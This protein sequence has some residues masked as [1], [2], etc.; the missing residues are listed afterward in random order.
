MT[1]FLITGA[2]T[3]IGR[4]TAEALGTTGNT[5]WLACRSEDKA[6]P[7]A[8]AIARRG[9]HARIVALDLGDLASVRRAASTVLTDTEPLHVLI[10]NAGI[11]GPRG[12]TKDGFEITFGTNHL[13]PFLLTRLLLPKL[14]ENA[15]ARV[16]T[17]ASRAHRGAKG[18]DFAHL[19]EPTRSRTAIAEYGVSKLANI[20]FTRELARRLDGSGTTA[21][22][23]HPGVVASD[24]WRSVPAPLRWASKLLMISNEDGARTSVYCA[25]ATEVAT[26]SGRYYDHGKVV[27][28]SRVA[29]N[30]VLARELW[31]RSVEWTGASDLSPR[32]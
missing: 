6:R 10:N 28:P 5:V 29:Q 14:R 2:N 8:D 20:L 24:L 22:A 12:L 25:T 18:I 11:A 4:S 31:E 9:G 23:L 1:T 21:Y 15:Q 30:D 13:G 32:L 7:V 16:V 3:G 17:V 19:R 27:A 26:Q